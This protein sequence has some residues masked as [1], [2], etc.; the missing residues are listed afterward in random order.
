MTSYKSKYKDENGQEEIC[1]ESDGSSLK[2]RIRGI[3]FEGQ[4]F[5]ELEPIAGDLEKAQKIFYLGNFNYLSNCEI[6]VALPIR[7]CTLAGFIEEPL[8]VG[9]LLNE[10]EEPELIKFALTIRE[11]IFSLFEGMKEMSFEYQLPALQSLLP[12]GVHIKSCFFC[13]FSAY[14]VAGWSGFGSLICFKDIKEK[15][16]SVKSKEEYM[17]VAE[18]YGV[19][20]QETFLCSEYEDIKAGQWQYK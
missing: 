9:V 6:E 8:M 5:E 19:S 17:D 15:I 16:I 12:V 7:L 2:T 20:V 11:D 4:S 18:G 1:F 14:S 13:A 3:D 10:S